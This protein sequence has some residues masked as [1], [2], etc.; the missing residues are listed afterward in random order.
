MTQLSLSAET[1]PQF[2]LAVLVT[3]IA[4]R[5]QF[6]RGSNL[7]EQWHVHFGFHEKGPVPAP[8]V[9]HLRETLEI[10]LS[11]I[12]F[13]DGRRVETVYNWINII[14]AQGASAG[15]YVDLHLQ[16]WSPALAETPLIDRPITPS[17]SVGKTNHLVNVTMQGRVDLDQP[18][19]PQ[20][21]FYLGLHDHYG[22]PAVAHLVEVLATAR[23]TLGITTGNSLAELG[24]AVTTQLLAAGQFPDLQAGSFTLQ[25]A[26]ASEPRP[27]AEKPGSE[28]VALERQ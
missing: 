21:S 7:R 27:T 1:A 24:L 22:D 11:E 14:G 20:T 10:D 26:A 28:Q 12:A 16:D 5:Q 9:A 8:L 6:E 15:H 23:E 3:G 18:E 13:E 19:N 4:T 17:A 2:A 25:L